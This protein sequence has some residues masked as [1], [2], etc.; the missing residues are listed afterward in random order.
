MEIHWLL[1]TKEREKILGYILEHPSE[2]INMNGLARK[3]NLSPGQIHK[4]VSILRKT[5]LVSKDR[6]QELPITSA[7]RLLWNLLRIQKEEL[8]Q[9]LNRHFPKSK[10]IGIFGSWARGSNLEES[11][12]DIWIKMEKEPGDLEL[13]KAR[14]ELERKMGVSVDI[15]VVT[16]QR[17]EYFKQKS[18]AFYFSLYNGILMWGEGL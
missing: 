12:L 6:L 16:P 1:S 11:D 18:D 8:I 3:L 4:Y 13:A 17:L 15:T 14:K 2:K 5:G 10:G 7:L 9:T